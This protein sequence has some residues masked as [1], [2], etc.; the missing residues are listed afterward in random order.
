MFCE[1]KALN[2]LLHST[3]VMSNAQWEDQRFPMSA[4]RDGFTLAEQYVRERDAGACVCVRV[5]VCVCACVC[6]FMCFSVRACAR[7]SN[8]RPW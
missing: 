4:G 5:R 8:A 2:K 1:Q 6:V 3:Q 7:V